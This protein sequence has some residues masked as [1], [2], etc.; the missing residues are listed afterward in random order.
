M[1]TAIVVVLVFGAMLAQGDPWAWATWTLVVLVFE[2]F[3]YAAYRNGYDRG[4]D[5][6]LTPGKLEE[7]R[8]KLQEEWRRR[9][10]SILEELRRERKAVEGPDPT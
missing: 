10:P 6:A 9:E 3:A 7:R 1:L 2:A 5:D 8:R 4:W